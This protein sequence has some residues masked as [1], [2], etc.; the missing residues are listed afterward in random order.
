MEKHFSSLGK[1]PKKRH[2]M[3]LLHPIKFMWNTIGE[4][5]EVCYGD[6]K[7]AE[8]NE[9]YGDTTKLSEV[10]QVWI[11]KKTR[12]VCWQTIITVVEERPVENKVVADE[13]YQFLT[14]PDI[15]NEYLSSHH[16]TGKMIFIIYKNVLCHHSRSNDKYF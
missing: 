2:L 8:Y 4:Q 11:D 14:R 12:L 15:Q 6:I 10:L 9:S 13:I 3:T 5:L 7:S 1:Q 16:Q